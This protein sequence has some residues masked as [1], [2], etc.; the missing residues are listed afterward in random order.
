MCGNRMSNVVDGKNPATPEF[1]P[2]PIYQAA[3]EALNRGDWSRAAGLAG[4]LVQQLPG[5]AGVHFVVGVAAMNLQQMPQALHHLQVAV[6]LNP[7]RADYAAQLAKVLSDG[8]MLREAQTVADAAVT[9]GPAD[10]MTADTLGV[11]FTRCNAHQKAVAMFARA[12]E[13][14]PQHASFRFN[15]ATSLTFAGDLVAAEREYEACLARNPQYWKAHLALAKL[16]KVGPDDHHLDRLRALLGSCPESNSEGRMYLHLALSAELE[17]LRDD[18]AAF[19]HLVAGKQAG[20]HARHYQSSQDTVVF[21]ALRAA[22]PEAISAGGT[23]STTGSTSEE[24]IFIVGMPRSGTTLVDRILSSHSQVHAAGELQNFGVLLKRASGS[25]TP[26]LIDED[27]IQRSGGL[28]WQALGDAYV[29]STRPG[30]GLK[31]H[32]TDKLPHNFLYL[33]HIARALPKAKIICLRRNPMDTCLGNFRQLFAL[34]SPF[35]DYSFD[36]LD[37]GRYYLQFDALMRHWQQV[38]P[39]RILEVHYETLVDAPEATIRALVAHCE[40]P[41][42]DACLQFQDNAAPVATASAVQVREPLH[43]GALHRW[44]RFETQLQPLQELLAQGGAAL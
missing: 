10:A 7:G 29:A 30:T 4:R 9:A 31:P 11:V 26:A 34:S 37:T 16:R 19:G 8:S 18:A 36:M 33:G 20:G 17:D 23:R 12:V 1:D 5:H 43:R 15:L 40:L 21:E 13:L 24:P 28:P 38:L 32:F 27:C 41:W 2:R 3:V 42:E 25:T 35:Y 39:G 44:K 6:Q 22:F 14:F